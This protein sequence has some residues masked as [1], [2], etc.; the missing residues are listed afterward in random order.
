MYHS[1]KRN[2]LVSL[3]IASLLITLSSCS[4]FSLDLEKEL[5]DEK[6]VSIVKVTVDEFGAET[7]VELPEEKR[8]LF[9]DYLKELKY[10]KRKNWFGIKMSIWD[11]E[12]FLI[13]YENHTVKFGEHHFVLRCKDEVIKSLKLDGVYPNETFKE[14]FKLFDS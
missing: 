2:F 4:I 12:Y 11:G 10:T 1:I 3:L 13:N 7:Q 9:N 6:V 5:P 14:L 8:Q